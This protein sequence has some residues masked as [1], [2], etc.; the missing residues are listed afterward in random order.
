MFKAKTI[1]NE[2]KNLNPDI[3]KFV[4]KLLLIVKWILIFKD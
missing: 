3:L 2:I 1:I 4:K